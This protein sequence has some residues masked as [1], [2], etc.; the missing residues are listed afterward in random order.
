MIVKC[1]LHFP[2]LYVNDFSSKKVLQNFLIK[3][4]PKWRHMVTQYAGC[5][6]LRNISQFM[7]RRFHNEFKVI[8]QLFILFIHETIQCVTL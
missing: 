6:T 5:R 4:L 8:E 2:N 1:L 7:E 3:H